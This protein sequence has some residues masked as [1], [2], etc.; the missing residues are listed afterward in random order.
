MQAFGAPSLR[1]QSVGDGTAACQRCPSVPLANTSTLALS[2]DTTPGSVTQGPPRLSQTPQR[3]E[4][5]RCI[6]LPLPVRVKT[7][8]CPAPGEAASGPEVKPPPSSSHVFQPWP[9]HHLCQRPASVP[10]TKTSSRPALQAT[11]AGEEVSDPPSGCQL[12]QLP[13][14]EERCQS[15]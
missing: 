1:R 12:P 6:R 3:P 9:S 7:S 13:P 2:C 15:P 11:A 4:K 10:R 5:A 8:S 14:E